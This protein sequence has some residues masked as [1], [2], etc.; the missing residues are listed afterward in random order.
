MRQYTTPPKV[1]HLC[2]SAAAAAYRGEGKG[3]CDAIQ[4]AAFSLGHSY[5]DVTSPTPG[6]GGERDCAP[7]VA[8][9]LAPV[10]SK[11]ASWAYVEKL[12]AKTRLY[13]PW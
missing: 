4:A 1:L 8:A 3:M 5:A 10:I 2:D 12:S 11:A 13:R 6:C 9:A 7:R